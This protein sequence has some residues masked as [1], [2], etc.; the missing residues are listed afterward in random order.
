MP[1][2]ELRSVKVYCKAYIKLIRP[3]SGSTMAICEQFD[4]CEDGSVADMYK[5]VEEEYPDWRILETVL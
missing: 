5:R 3:V 2:I 4:P 1:R